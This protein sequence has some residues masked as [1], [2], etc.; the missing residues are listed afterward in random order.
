LKKIWVMLLSLILVFSVVLT[1]CGGSTETNKL[2]VTPKPTPTEQ[3]K[4]IE[5]I[6]YPNQALTVVI[7]YG[8]GGGTDQVARIIG[9]LI[10]ENGFGKPVVGVNKVGGGG[11]VGLTET[12]NS[13]SDGYTIV[14]STSNISTLRETG[15][16]ELI[17]SDFE[18]IIAVNFDAP[19]L[20]V[21]SDSE[22]K[23]AEEF[24]TY[25]KENTVNIGTGSPGGLWHVGAIKLQKESNTKFNIIPSSTGGASASVS[26]MGGHVAAIV[27]PPNEAIAQIKSG[28]FRVLASMTPDRIK[29]FPEVPTFKE[30]GY[31]VEI[32]SLRGYLAPKGTPKEIIKIL[33]DEIKKAMDSSKFINY[34]DEQVSNVIYMDS[35]GYTKYLEKELSSYSQ[36]I[37]EAG[38]SKK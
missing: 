29:A 6:D 31:D 16:T 37:K 36:I 20:M 32:L 8:A 10:E 28:E 25:A 5:K 30:L 9:G 23:T 38:L 13:K 27:I 19:V 21:R 18:P 12:A 11:A 34:M 15:N 17:Y 3:N 2:E 24:L 22:W 14:L 33:H 4:E 7:P 35:E 26:L 1:G